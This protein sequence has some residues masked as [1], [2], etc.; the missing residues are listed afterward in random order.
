MRAPAAAKHRARGLPVPSPLSSSTVLLSTALHRRCSDRAAPPTTTRAA[1]LALL[2]AP[3]G[4]RPFGTWAQIARTL[5]HQASANSPR[6]HE[7]G[8]PDFLW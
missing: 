6:M 8:R 7:H 4:C 2:S 5:W 3:V 1:R